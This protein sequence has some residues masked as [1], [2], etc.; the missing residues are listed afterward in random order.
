MAFSSSPLR[1]SATFLL[2]K[3]HVQQSLLRS[4]GTGARGSRGH[5][6]FTKYRQGLGGRHLQGEYWDAPTVEEWQ[7]WNDSVFSYGSEMLEFK[8]QVQDEVFPIQLE[9]ATAVLPKTTSNF[10]LLSELYHQTKVHSVEK[11][12]GLRMGD[13]LNMDGKGG[14]CHESFQLEGGSTMETEP[15]VLAH[16][17]GTVTMLSHGVDK[18]DSRFLMCT[19]RAPQLDGKHVAFA[20]LHAD[21]LQLVQEWEES[22]FTKRGRPTVDMIMITES[23]T[24]DD[25]DAQESA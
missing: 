22:I 7:E 11:G 14:H 18:V 9:L 1:R 24:T 8:M 16:L 12:V 25:D 20:R 13:I 23:T 21:S 17:P 15:F 5:G 10:K 4:F 2:H 3:C 19:H 6:W